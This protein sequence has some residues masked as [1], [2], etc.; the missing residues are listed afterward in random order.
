MRKEENWPQKSLTEL[1]QSGMNETTKHMEK[2]SIGILRKPQG[3]SPFPGTALF[4][5]SG[6][7]P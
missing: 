3:S 1:L 4:F 7:Q 6:A 5:I 2:P